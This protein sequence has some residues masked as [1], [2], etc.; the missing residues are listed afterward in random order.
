MG[1]IILI[2]FPFT[3]LTSQKTRPAVVLSN[4]T[5]H[6]EDIVIGAISSKKRAGDISIVSTDLFEGALPLISYCKIGK[7]VTLHTKIIVSVIGKLHR[8]KINEI[9]TE[10]RDL[11]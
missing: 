8:E 10:T 2:P 3:D 1:E 6:S 11:F 4:K 7:I 5:P 9:L